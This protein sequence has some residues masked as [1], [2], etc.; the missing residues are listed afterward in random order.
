MEEYRKGYRLKDKVLRPSLVAVS[1][2]TAA[3]KKRE[4]RNKQMETQITYRGGIVI[5]VK[6]L[7]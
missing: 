2:K 7:V 5:W 4:K 3:G 1:K 6:Q